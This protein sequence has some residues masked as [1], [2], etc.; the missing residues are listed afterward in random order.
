MASYRKKQ[1]SPTFTVA[2][3]STSGSTA[4]F[5]CSQFDDVLFH[6]NVTAVTA[7]SVTL[8]LQTS[9]DEGATWYPLLETLG[10]VDAISAAAAWTI[11]ARAPIGQRVRLVYTIATGPVA[12]TAIAEGSKRGHAGG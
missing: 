5:S 9:P 6:V 8:S 7:G 2:S 4:D 1:I 12:F 10:K 11:G 3:T